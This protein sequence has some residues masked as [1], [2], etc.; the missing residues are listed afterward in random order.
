RSGKALCIQPVVVGGEIAVNQRTDQVGFG[1]NLGV[2]GK[3]LVH[4]ALALPW[5]E[6]HKKRK[7]LGPAQRFPG[8]P[9]R[10]N[11][12]ED[13]SA[14]SFGQYAYFESLQCFIVQSAG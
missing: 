1:W 11:S 2:G 6:S 12:T 5:S 9:L 10:K 13:L 7:R 8:S 4:R 14:G 3:H